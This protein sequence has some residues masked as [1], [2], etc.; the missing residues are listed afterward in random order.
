MFSSGNKYMALSMVSMTVSSSKRTHR[1]DHKSYD[2]SS[3]FALPFWGQS[4]GPAPFRKEPRVGEFL[5]E[6]LASLQI[7]TIR[8]SSAYV[9]KGYSCHTGGRHRCPF[10]GSHPFH[11]S[12]T[13]LQ[14][15]G[16]LDKTP[17]HRAEPREQTPGT[18]S[19]MF[20]IRWTLTNQAPGAV[21][22]KAPHRVAT[23][24]H[25]AA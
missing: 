22:G 19:R 20:C 23:I 8:S 9:T 25:P 1:D 15:R 10:H 12:A 5:V 6:I 24:W 3:S 2:S 13:C 4:Q 16:S 18:V 17:S 7:E 21:S 11:S 14:V